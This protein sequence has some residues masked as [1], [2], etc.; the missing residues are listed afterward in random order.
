MRTKI[1]VSALCALNLALLAGCDADVE[2]LQEAITDS[3]SPDVTLPYI[4][5]SISRINEI[6]SEETT[7]GI[8]GTRFAYETD[9]YHRGTNIKFIRHPQACDNSFT[10]IDWSDGFVIRAAYSG[11]ANGD[12]NPNRPEDLNDFRSESEEW[13]FSYG[14]RGELAEVKL[15]SDP[16]TFKRFTYH[17]TR[18]FFDSIVEYR[19]GLVHK[20]LKYQYSFD[21]V[22]PI[23]ILE[24]G[25]SHDTIAQY[26]FEYE[27][28]RHQESRTNDPIYRSRLVGMPMAPCTYLYLQG[29]LWAWHF[30]HP[31]KRLFKDGVLVYEASF[32]YGFPSDHENPYGYPERVHYSRMDI[33]G[34]MIAFSEALFTEVI[35]E[36]LP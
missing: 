29:P 2:E 20:T 4:P 34:G 17:T 8:S 14:R 11:V 26:T 19:E 1:I 6:R 23:G 36:E 16:G 22:Y 18:H 27:E 5:L 15:E 24:L 25:P 13:L 33:S 30:P 12:F 21:L 10:F 9:Q 28:R 31:V 7:A 35:Q 32:E 3:F